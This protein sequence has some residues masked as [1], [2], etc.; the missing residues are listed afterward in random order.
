[1]A[2]IDLG[3][4]KGDKGISLRNRGAWNSTAQYVNNTEYVDIVSY[5]G[6]LWICAAT[7]TNSTP[8]KT[9]SKWDIAAEGVASI[10]NNLTTTAEGSALDARQGPVI[11]G[12]VDKIYNDKL[13][14][15]D[16][17]D[18]VTEE[19][20]F[21]DALAVKEL[22][23]NLSRI[24]IGAEFSVS[25]EIPT[26][27]TWING[28]EIYR[29]TYTTTQ[30]ISPGTSLTIPVSIPNSDF[31]IDTQNSFM[32]TTGVCYNLPLLAYGGDSNENVYVWLNSAG[33]RIGSSKGGWN[34]SWEKIVTIRYTK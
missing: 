2:T 31:W 32:R 12:L 11:K 20:F 3:Q 26:G 34:E 16:E 17:I 27:E 30:P 1:M 24:L 8:S 19:G 10:A 15:M 22:N 29:R 13:V 4:V 7:N 5:G 33:I 18:L 28:K 21:V 9:N 25:S 6:S 23:S 14:S